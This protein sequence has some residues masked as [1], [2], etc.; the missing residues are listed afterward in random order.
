MLQPRVDTLRC[1]VGRSQG[2]E[3]SMMHRTVPTTKVYLAPHVNS[4]KVERLSLRGVH[5]ENPLS[6]SL[7]LVKYIH[8]L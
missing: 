6:L 8:M 1:L 5:Q 3:H 2:V 4:A 7:T